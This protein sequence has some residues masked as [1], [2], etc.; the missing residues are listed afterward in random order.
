MHAVTEEEARSEGDE[1]TG[2]QILKQ[3][4]SAPARQIAD[5]SASTVALSSQRC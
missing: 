1:R 5:N 4:L 3:A 2:I